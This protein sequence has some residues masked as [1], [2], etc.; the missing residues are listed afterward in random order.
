MVYNFSALSYVALETY[1]VC[2]FISSLNIEMATIGD[3]AYN[4]PWYRMSRNETIVVQMIIRRSQQSCELKGLDVFVC[5]LETFLK[6]NF[7]LIF[8]CGV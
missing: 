3:I 7:Y 5:S 1:V 6:V 2:Y 4:S 8:K